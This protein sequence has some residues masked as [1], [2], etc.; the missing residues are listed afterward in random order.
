M[1]VAFRGE[2]Q[3][4][5]RPIICS[6][7]GEE[8][9][10]WFSN[11]PNGPYGHGLWKGIFKGKEVFA[12]QLSFKVNKGD[13]VWFWHDPWFGTASRRKMTWSRSL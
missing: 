7:Y 6:K 4:L 10:G 5:W 8:V 11:R 13:R 3:S 9:G 12:K 2:R 1:V